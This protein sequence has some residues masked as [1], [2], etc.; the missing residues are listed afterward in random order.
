L[1]C[2]YTEYASAAKKQKANGQQAVSGNGPGQKN[3]YR[4][5]QWNLLFDD[6]QQHYKV[7][8]NTTV[9]KLQ[10]EAKSK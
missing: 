8:F 6:N 1:S 7:N 2:S 3:R 10:S 4:K 9:P 5:I